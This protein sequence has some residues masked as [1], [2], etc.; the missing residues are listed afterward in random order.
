MANVNVK[1]PLRYRLLFLLGS[2]FN[3]DVKVTRAPRF[4]VDESDEPGD[5]TV[6]ELRKS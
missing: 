2:I 5:I 3:Y 1:P 6:I 4:M